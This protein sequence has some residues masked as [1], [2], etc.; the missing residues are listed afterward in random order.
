MVTA[1]QQDGH[2]LLARERPVVGA[3][4]VLLGLRGGEHDDGDRAQVGVLLDLREDLPAL[5]DICRSILTPIPSATRRK[6]S[7]AGPP[8]Q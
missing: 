3:R 5:A 7:R 6:G 1:N 8:N 4:D 2:P